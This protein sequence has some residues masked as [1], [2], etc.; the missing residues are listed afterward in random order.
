MK[1]SQNF[2]ERRQH[3]RASVQNIIVG[4]LNAD[5]IVTTGLINDISLGG[6][7]F[8]HEL[9]IEPVASSINSIDLIADSN[10]V[11][12]IPCEYAWK[13]II[14]RES[15]FNSRYLRQCGIQFGT[16]NPDQVFQLRSIIN[17]CTSLGTKSITSNVR[18]TLG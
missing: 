14:D 11:N 5:E 3:E 13:F 6:V 9:G 8:T 1:G 16:L 17:R 7:S 18:L 15:Y 10:Y 4:I 2:T 12:D